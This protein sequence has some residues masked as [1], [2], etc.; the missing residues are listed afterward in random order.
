M[1]KDLAAL[2]GRTGTLHTLT[3]DLQ[4]TVTVKDVRKVWDR[5]DVLVTPEAGS[6]DAWVSLARVSIAPETAGDTPGASVEQRLRLAQ[7][8]PRNPGLRHMV[9]VVDEEPR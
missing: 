3:E 8:D 2:I 1:V 9:D 7:T 5:V 4:V 6:G